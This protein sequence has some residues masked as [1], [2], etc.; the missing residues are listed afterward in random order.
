M[1]F[2]TGPD[3]PIEV[4]VTGS[5]PPATVFAHGL[6]ES[7]EETRPFGSGVDGSRIFFHFRGHG[8]T[9]AADAPW[10]Y[11]TLAAEL[12]AV[13]DAYAARR[14]LGVSLGAGTLLRAAA[15]TPQAFD[16]LVLV[17]PAAIAEPRTDPA[18][19]QMQ[20]IAELVHRRDQARLTAALIS[21]QPASVRDR[22]E[23]RRWVDR[24]ARRLVTTG[25][26]RALRELASQAPLDHLA[27]LSAIRCDVLV[28]GQEADDAHP[29]RIAREL[30]ARLPNGRVHIFDGGGLL[31]SHRAALRALIS[32][33]LN[34]D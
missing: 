14:G 18:S 1:P 9:V 13:R 6:G 8:N 20:E 32:G 31:W 4:L 19:E 24:R 7:I 28:V 10:T 12:C 21:E 3:G 34:A 16:R 17:L 29:A 23:V 2:I 26:S 30:A 25:A 22:I 5:G 15:S 27:S 33:F 11:A